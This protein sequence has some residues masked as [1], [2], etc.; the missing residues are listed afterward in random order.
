MEEKHKLHK[1]IKFSSHLDKQH[2]LEVDSEEYK[3]K[4]TPDF[5][6]MN[7]ILFWNSLG[8]FFYG[9]VITYVSNQLMEATGT[10]IGVIFASMTF[11]G[12]ISS[13]IVG[14]LT[15]RMS[16][17]KLVLWGSAG[18]GASYMITYLAIIMDSLPL[19]NFGVFMLGFGVGF[20][21]PPFDALISQKSSKYHRSYAFGNREGAL[22]N[23]NFLGAVLSI[24]IFTLT[25][26]L[27]PEN[28]FLVYS[29][30]VLYTISNLY[31]GF[32]FNHDID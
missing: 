20:F 25:T 26:Y 14:F 5:E 30:L 10:D 27:T 22:G 1:F 4:T 2:K 19:F 8:F 28:L 29:P 21:W 12:L 16:K 17:K 11:G 15:D 32:K 24:I 23:G 13:P 31:A 18:R 9:F 6:A 7:Q 3:Q